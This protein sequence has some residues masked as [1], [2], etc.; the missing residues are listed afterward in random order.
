MIGSNGGSNGSNDNSPPTPP[1]VGVWELLHA[2]LLPQLPRTSARFFYTTASTTSASFDLPTARLSFHRLRLT[3]SRL[4]TTWR[5]I[6]LR[7]MTIRVFQSVSKRFRA[8]QSVSS[9]CFFRA[10]FVTLANATMTQCNLHNNF[11]RF[12]SIIVTHIIH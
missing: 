9:P 11:V 3:P 10:L 5:F 12:K 1:A 4:Q 8:F 2:R 6:G 7:Q